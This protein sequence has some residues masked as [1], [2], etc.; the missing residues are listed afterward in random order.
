MVIQFIN[1]LKHGALAL[2]FTATTMMAAVPIAHATDVNGCDFDDSVPGEWSLQADCSSSA[3]INIP[4]DTTVNGNGY[5]ISPAFA[6]TTNS[7]NSAIGV[8]GVDN[9]TIND[10]TIDGSSGTDLHGINTYE[11]DNVA[12]N[13]V[14]S[15]NNRSGLVVNGSN[16]TVNNIE[17]AGNIW[18]GINVAQGSG[19]T[20]TSELTVNGVSAHSDAAHIYM[21]DTTQDVVLNDTNAQYAIT[22]PVVNVS[23]RLYTLIDVIAPDQVTGMD[24]IVDGTSMGCYPYITTRSIIVDWNDSEAADLDYYQYQADADMLAPFDFTTTVNV[25]ERSG[26]IR[27]QDG[28][29]NYRVRAVDTAG[30]TGEWSEWCGVTLDRQNPV[31]AITGPSDGDVVSGQVEVFGSVEDQNPWRYYAVVRDAS[32]SVVAGPGTVYEDTSFSNESLFTFDTTTVADGQYT[33]HLAA[34]DK[35][36]NRGSESEAQ[37]V[38]TVDNTAPQVELLSPERGDV[39]RGTVSL[40]GSITDENNL[41]HRFVVRDLS[42]NTVWNSGNIRNDADVVDAMTAFDSTTVEDGEYRIVLVGVDDVRNRDRDA[43]RIEVDNRPERIADCFW[44]QWR[45]YGFRNQGQCVRSVVRS[46]HSKHFRSGHRNHR[47]LNV[48]QLFFGSRRR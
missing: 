35:A 31:V 47:K 13:N 36:L 29:Y 27:D 24:I 25:S 4:A 33:V 20:E 8:I 22:E 30:N 34:R 43:V 9:V 42:G 7:N 40:S 38:V 1:R 32:N 17:T 28:T 44:G 45:D 16:V 41:L 39:L 48:Y 14:A 37:V 10:L 3:Q 15:F 12:L 5:T 19:V 2:G 18:H 6:K 23:D 26:Q 11:A 46:Y 21:D